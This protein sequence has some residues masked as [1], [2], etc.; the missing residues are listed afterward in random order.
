M[1]KR[2]QQ[3]Y[4]QAINR[5]STQLQRRPTPEEQ[6]ALNI[7]Q[8]V[9]SQLTSVALLDE[10]ARR[11][12]LSLSDEGLARRIAN[13]PAF[14]DSSGN[15]SAN[16]ARLVLQR[17]NLTEEQ[18]AAEE[19]KMSRRIQVMDAVTGGMALPAAFSDAMGTYN[20]ERRTIAAITPVSY[21]H[22]TLPTKA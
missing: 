6:A 9:L 11:L 22:L 8:Q 3:A 5:V 1:Y 13:E 2:Q 18:Y 10:E 17:A 4:G 16:T 12:G 15:Y 21:T 14:R 19:R 20:G 7:D